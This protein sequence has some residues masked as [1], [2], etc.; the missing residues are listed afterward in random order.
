VELNRRLRLVACLA[1]VVA[2]VTVELEFDDGERSVAA[3]QRL[4]ADLDP[5]QL[6]CAVLELRSLDRTRLVDALRS[7]EIVGGIE[8]L[9]AGI[10]RRHHSC[11]SEE[12]WFLAE[13]GHERLVEL[14]AACPLDVPDDLVAVDV[15]ADIELGVCAV[16]LAVGRADDAWRIDEIAMWGVTTCLVDELIG[17]AAPEVS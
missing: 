16:R 1:H 10:Y 8:H 7:I 15:M 5:C 6:R 17:S 14:L 11:G 12:R 2:G 4:D 13:L 3:Y 9:G